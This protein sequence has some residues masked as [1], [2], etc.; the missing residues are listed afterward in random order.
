VAESEETTA[1]RDLARRVIEQVAP[2]ELPVFG[3]VE[4]AYRRNP[5]KVLAGGRGRDE[6]L[7]FGV[8]FAG[9]LL[10]PVALAAITEVIRY[11]A[12]AV[13]G[14]VG[15][16]E[17]LRRRLHRGSTADLPQLSTEQLVQVREIVLAKALQAGVK[18]GRAKLLA[19][20]VAG[21]LTADPSTGD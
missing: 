1:E 21:A 16:K 11:L 4:Q 3:V 19:D 18:E 5:A 6:M 14:A 10:T 7:G 17:W 9:V 13:V 12:G 20:A 15:I 8:E 2:E